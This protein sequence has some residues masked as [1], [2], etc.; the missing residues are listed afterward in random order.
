MTIHSFYLPQGIEIGSIF[1]IEEKSHSDV[2]HQLHRVLRMKEGTNLY[3]LDGV[4]TRSTCTI[5]GIEK[6]YILLHCT[7]QQTYPAPITRELYLPYLRHNHLETVLEMCTQ[8]GIQRFIFIHTDFTDPHH[9]IISPTKRERFR[10]LCIE[11]MEQSEQWYIPELIFTEEHFTKHLPVNGYV[12]AIER[13]KYEHTTFS[14]TPQSLLIGPE[15]GWSEEELAY[16]KKD[17][18]CK[19]I[20]L[21]CNTVLRAETAAVAATARMLSL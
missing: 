15:G 21:C 10:K 8:L 5:T 3:F 9:A 20:D 19:T 14:S 7:Q 2:F 6:K 18:R 16:F 12:V 17:P 4:G 11:A 1:S 13:N